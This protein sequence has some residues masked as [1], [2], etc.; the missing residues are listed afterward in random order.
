MLKKMAATMTTARTTAV[1][2]G[3]PLRGEDGEGEAA[4]VE[5][6]AMMAGAAGAMAVM[7]WKYILVAW[8]LEDGVL[9][10]DLSMR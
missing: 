3:V 5:V 8:R 6:E 7:F 1:V 4:A 2:L 9:T 10:L